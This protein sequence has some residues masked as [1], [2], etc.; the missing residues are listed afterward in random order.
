MGQLSHYTQTLAKF[1]SKPS[2]SLLFWRQCPGTPLAAPRH[3]NHSRTLAAF[4]E[5]QS[6]RALQLTLGARI[7]ETNLPTA[8][9]SA[10]SV[11]CSVS[12]ASSACVVRT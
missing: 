1:D 2:P 4:Y 3:Y 9:C 11:P 6:Q 8:L 5:Q 10:S 12:V 7:A